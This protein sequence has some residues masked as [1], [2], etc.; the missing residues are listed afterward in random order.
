MVE[1]GPYAE[2]W[3]KMTAPVETHPAVRATSYK[4]VYQDGVLISEEKL[5]VNDKYKQ[6]K[7]RLYVASD[8]I[9]ENSVV[10]YNGLGVC[11]YPHLYSET[12]APLTIQHL[13][14]FKNGKTWNVATAEENYTP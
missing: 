10:D 12:G 6:M 4:R 1:Y 7:G 14:Y 11:V 13:V 5:N 2:S 8:C 9:I 3:N